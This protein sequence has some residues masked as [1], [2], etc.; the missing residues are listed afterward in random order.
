M[1]GPESNQP[2]EAVDAAFNRYVAATHAM[3]S[4]VAMKMNYDPSETTPK[5]LRVGVNAA[6]V[7]HSALA[8]L[9]VRKGV[10]TEEEYA[11]ALADGMEAE[12][13]MYQQWLQQRLGGNIRLG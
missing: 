10:I 5:H 3:Q 8:R 9:L 6:M 1:T 7:E 11:A 4:G 12:R 13:D 2:T